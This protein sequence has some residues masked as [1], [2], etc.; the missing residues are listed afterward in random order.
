MN[1]Q[2]I[3]IANQKGGFGKITTCA[4]AQR[5]LCIENGYS[6]VENPKLCGKSYGKWLDDT[7]RLKNDFF[8]FVP[9]FM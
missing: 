2:I 5:Y 4:A 3:A 1:A 9:P 7:I 6:I 8:N